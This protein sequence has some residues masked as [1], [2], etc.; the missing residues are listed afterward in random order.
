MKRLSELLYRLRNSSSQNALH[1]QGSL[2]L[3]WLPILE[4]LY[5]EG[6]IQNYRVDNL[7]VFIF[8]RYYRNLPALQGI[9]I[10]DKP[11]TS[12]YLQNNNLWKFSRSKGLLV[13]STTKGVKSH[14]ECLKLGLGGR[15]LFFV[16]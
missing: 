14:K 12:F 9:K 16:A 11:S 6:Y 10:F 3:Y 8:L 5:K 7:K 2:S 13:L 1:I 15:V 4:L